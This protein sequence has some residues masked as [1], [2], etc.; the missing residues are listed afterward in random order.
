MNRRRTVIV[1]VGPLRG[2][3]DLDGVHVVRLDSRVESRMDLVQRL[4]S[5]SCELDELGRDWLSA[6]DF[7]RVN[8]S[9]AA[10]TEDAGMDE[11]PG[12]AVSLRIDLLSRLKVAAVSEA[13]TGRVGQLDM[14]WLSAE[15]GLSADVVQAELDEMLVDGL[16]E[17]HVQTLG[18]SAA[19]GACRI[20]KEGLEELQSVSKR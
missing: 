8:A 16:I 20:T 3:T 17:P 5:C 19:K 1:E 7:D 4:K 13:A 6:G 12:K 9:F 10:D 11:D 14:D 2:L 18:K 15:L